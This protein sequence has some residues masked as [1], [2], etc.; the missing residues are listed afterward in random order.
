[1]LTEKEFQLLMGGEKKTLTTSYG[2]K[3]VID[4]FSGNTAR[5]IKSGPLKNDDFTRKQI[6]KDI[7]LID[8]ENISVEWHL[9]EGGS[10]DLIKYMENNGIKVIRYDI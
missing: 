2:K 6:R 5:E 1:V 4:N 3:R 9:F 10:E 8:K 7:D